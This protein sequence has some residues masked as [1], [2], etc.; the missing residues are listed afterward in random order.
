MPV[1]VAVDN[2]NCWR[3][4]ADLGTGTKEEDLD[5]LDREVQVVQEVLEV[6]EDPVFLVA[7]PQ[8]FLEGPVALV[9]LDDLASQED[10]VDQRVHHY[11]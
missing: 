4:P 6:R 11:P 10:L 8:L 9:F 7:L 3:K 2:R 5:S 1:E